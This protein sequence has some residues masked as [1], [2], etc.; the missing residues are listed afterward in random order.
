MAIIIDE[1]N[2]GWCYDIRVRYSDNTKALLSFSTKPLN[3]QEEVDK[4]EAKYLE[5]KT[6]IQIE[7]E[8]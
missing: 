3:I 7:G 6:D 1:R 2:L 4:I 5:R 8:I